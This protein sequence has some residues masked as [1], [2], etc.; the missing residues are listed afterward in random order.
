MHIDLPADGAA[1]DQGAAL[2]LEGVGTDMEDGPLPA[3]SLAWSS[4][5]DGSLGSGELLITSSLSVGDHLLTLQASDSSG[6]TATASVHVTVRRVET[7]VDASAGA[8][9]SGFPWV[10]ILIFGGVVVIAAAAFGL[11]RRSKSRSQ[12]R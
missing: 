5:K 12:G 11:G 6:E 10:P 7:E 2:V 1:V 4:D 9:S 8:G 3:S